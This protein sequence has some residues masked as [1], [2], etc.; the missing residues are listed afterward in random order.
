MKKYDKIPRKIKKVMKKNGVWN[1]YV[2]ER[3]REIEK[4]ESL[5]LIFNR[6]YKNVRKVMR[7]MLHRGRR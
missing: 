5:N 6:D 2:E 1:T 7:R 4:E 3:R